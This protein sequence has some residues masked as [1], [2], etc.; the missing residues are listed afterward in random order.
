MDLLYE[1]RD[2]VGFFDDES[3]PKKSHDPQPLNPIL[4]KMMKSAWPSGTFI[5]SISMVF[6]TQ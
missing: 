6:K 3:Y 1:S 4:S 2:Q 5:L